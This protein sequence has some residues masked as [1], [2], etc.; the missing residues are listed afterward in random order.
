M[1][2]P[3]TLVIIS[4]SVPHTD[5]TPLFSGI[6]A[7]VLVAAMAL[8][9]TWTQRGIAEKMM[10]AQRELSDA[11]TA[12]Q[13]EIAKQGVDA[14]LETA[15]RARIVESRREWMRELRQSVAG[16]EAAAFAV[17]DRSPIGTVNPPPTD[18]QRLEHRAEI[19]RLMT[20]IVL[21]LDENKQEHRAIA[22]GLNA[23]AGWAVNDSETLPPPKPNES[24]ILTEARR[25]ADPGAATVALDRAVRKVLEAAW[26]KIRLGE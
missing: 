1:V 15:R 24:I 5:Y 8:Y 7:S 23:V 22:K 10:I 14:Q 13:R 16:F 9:S 21:L 19:M 11:A 17:A 12:T 6:A 26:Q 18:E 4:K 20:T 3:D 25:F 2:A